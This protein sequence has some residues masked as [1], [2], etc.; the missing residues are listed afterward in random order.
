VRRHGC[1]PIAILA[2]A[3]FT[4]APLRGLPSA[5]GRLIE[6]LR[7][8]AQTQD[9]LEILV[10]AA[11]VYYRAAHQPAPETVALGNAL[12]DLAMTGRWPTRAGRATATGR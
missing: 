4:H 12:A 10:R 1:P 3:E 5:E 6:G 9:A 8:A 11:A 7:E 2:P